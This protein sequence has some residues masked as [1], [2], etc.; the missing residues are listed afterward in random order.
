MKEDKIFAEGLFNKTI[1]TQYGE[2]KKHSFRVDEFIAFL[3][4]HKNEDGWCTVMEKTSAT[5]KV[6]YELDTW[7]PDKS[8]AAKAT[9]AVEVTES[10][11]TPF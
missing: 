11:N 2:L 10:D 7:K 3:N 5:G 9:V 6:Y 8:Q 4:K 1:E